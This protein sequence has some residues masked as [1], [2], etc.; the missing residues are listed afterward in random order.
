VILPTLVISFLNKKYYFAVIE[1]LSKYNAYSSGKDTEKYVKS[2]F[3]VRLPLLKV[4]YLCKIGRKWPWP[5][6][7]WLG[8]LGSHHSGTYP[9]KSVILNVVDF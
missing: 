6:N 4:C 3:Q 9:L 7:V 1:T 8:V 2:S 5:R